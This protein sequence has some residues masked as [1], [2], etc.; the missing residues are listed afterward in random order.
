MKSKETCPIPSASD[1]SSSQLTIPN[2]CIC[3]LLILYGVGFLSHLWQ[4]CFF[5]DNFQ[6][7]EYGINIYE[8]NI[9][10]D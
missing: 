6:E 9:R 7:A 2:I 5:S 4:E 3:R 10:K 1:S 8:Q